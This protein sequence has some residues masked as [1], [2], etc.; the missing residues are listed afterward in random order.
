MSWKVKAGLAAGGAALGLGAPALYFWDQ[1]KRGKDL[2]GRASNVKENLSGNLG[3]AAGIFAATALGTGLAAHGAGKY[4][5][6]MAKHREGNAWDKAQAIYQ[7][8]GVPSS[9]R[10]RLESMERTNLLQEADFRSAR[11]L[12]DEL[13][14]HYRGPLAGGSPTFFVDPTTNMSQRVRDLTAGSNSLYLAFLEE[15]DKHGAGKAAAVFPTF[16]KAGK[17]VGKL[18]K[19]GGKKTGKKVRELGVA[20]EPRPTEKITPNIWESKNKIYASNIDNSMPKTTPGAPTSAFKRWAAPVASTIGIVG[21]GGMLAQDISRRRQEN[22]K[23]SN[24]DLKDVLVRSII[25]EI[26][27]KRASVA[28]KLLTSAGILGGGAMVA[29]GLGRYARNKFDTEYKPALDRG[30]QTLNFAEK[31][32]EALPYIA[33]IGGTALGIGGGYAL[34]KRAGERQIDEAI[35]LVARNRNAYNYGRALQHGRR[36]THDW[37]RDMIKDIRST[38]RRYERLN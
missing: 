30:E 9:F 29:S 14:P 6:G 16:I 24:Y 17:A 4:R 36:K 7:K 31:A 35:N 1:Y 32:T 15:E 26:V 10:N 19:K 12:R 34:G 5:H 20:G 37:N 8:G 21:G 23:R 13:R 28:G 3:R 2:R 22:T 38:R 18:F 25:K 33:A 11:R 27:D